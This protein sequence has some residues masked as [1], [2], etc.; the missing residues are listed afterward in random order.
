[1]FEE[2]NRQLTKLKEDIRNKTKYENRM[3]ELSRELREQQDE[4]ER[5]KLRLA[6]EEKDVERLTGTSLSGLFYSMIGRKEEKLEREQL[7]V[8]EVKAKYDMAARSVV[9]I[10]NDLQ[11]LERK[12]QEVRYAEFEYEKILDEKEKVI[13][14]NNA[15]LA[16]LA[17]EQ[18]DLSVQLKELKEAVRAGEAVLEDLERADDSLG[19]AGNWGT[20]DM[21][22]GG[23]ISTHMKHSRIDEA[24]E[25]IESAQFS[26]RR[27]GKELKDVQMA[28]DIEIGIGSFLK[29]SDYFFDG[30]ISDWLVQGR[31]RDTQDEVQEKISEVERIVRRLEGEYSRLDTRLADTKRKYESII[32]LA[33]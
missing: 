11:E 22:G 2:A 4:A 12:F 1:M 24:M 20:Y 27:F 3:Q 5:W 32:E 17:E 30:F 13:L 23:M 25:H 15:E 28:L 10:Q 19:S 6:D 33:E 29:F 14:Q 8:L 31:I 7:E 18:A 9:D 26:L 16:A 21:L